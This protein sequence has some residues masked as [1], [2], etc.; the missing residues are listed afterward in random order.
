MDHDVSGRRASP[1]VCR[2]CSWQ[3]THAFSTGDKAGLVVMTFVL[4]EHDEGQL[5]SD[6]ADR[7]ATL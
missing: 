6:E 7:P 4:I 2:R 5:E 1:A 3:R